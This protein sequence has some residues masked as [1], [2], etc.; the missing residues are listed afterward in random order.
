MNKIT[1]TILAIVCTQ[2]ATIFSKSNY[3]I[4]IGSNPGGV[5]VKVS[6]L[7][8]K[9]NVIVFK[10]KTPCLVRLP[11]SKGY[12]RKARYLVEL[13]Y[14]GYD[15]LTVNIDYKLDAWYFGNIAFGGLIG[16]LIVDPLTGAMYKPSEEFILETLEK[17]TLQSGRAE[18]R[19]L[20]YNSLDEEVRKSL[21][22]L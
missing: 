20:E 4:P 13:S 19:I 16:F 6:S 8:R 15:T 1:L 9:S 12:F 22:A 10:G 11:S 5:D 14:P 3:T 21:I 18:F 7:R 17:S 2:C